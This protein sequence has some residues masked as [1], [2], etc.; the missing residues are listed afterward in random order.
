MMQ[1][2]AGGTVAHH[3]SVD[4]E[5]YFHVSAFE[6]FVSRESW[7]TM[8]SRVERSVV[9]LLELFEMHGARA[10]FFTL[11]WLA[12]RQPHI[13]RNI[14]AAGH[15]IASHGWDHRRV[16]AQTRTAFQMS[17]RESRAVLEDISG[18][19]VR[20]FRAPSFSITRG[21]EWALEC[22]VEA[23]YT[24][25]SSLFPIHRRGY[26][27]PGVPRDPFTF[28]TPAGPILEFPIATISFANMLLP[29]GGGGYF[30][31]FPYEWSRRAFVEC[32]KRRAPATFYLHPWEIDPAQPRL[33]VPPLVQLR[34]YRGLSR[35]QP[36]LERLLSEFSF[37]TLGRGLPTLAGT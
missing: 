11:G 32:E 23:G 22:L 28:D 9:T 5:E 8:P 34:H 27:Y 14:A 13:V 31:Q 29:A 15:E 3:L 30:R 21:N 4:V 17:V 1:L 7:D 19:Q 35:T 2:G 36:R 24:Y 12:H 25:D 18:Q 26:G 16:T 37:T 20:G 10:T 6:R 33:A